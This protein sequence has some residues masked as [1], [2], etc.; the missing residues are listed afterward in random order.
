MTIELLTPSAFAA[1]SA[2][3]VVFDTDL[4]HDL[5]DALALWIAAEL[6]RN[7][8]VVTNDETNGNHRARYARELLDQM[9]RTDVPVVAGR[10]LDGA[11]DRF[12]MH[13]RVPDAR[14]VLTD[15]VEVVTSACENSTQ[16]LI[17]VGC[18]P[19][20]NVAEFFITCPHHIEQIEFTMMG[21]WLDFY[22]NPSRASH[23][24]RMD[25]A[26]F[27][28]VLRAAHQPRLVLSTHTNTDH[29]AITPD[30]HLYTWL[31]AA[32]APPEVELIAANATQ[33]FGHRPSSW[34]N[35]PVTLAAALAV[36]VVEFGT[37]TVRIAK[38]G[39]IHRDPAGRVIEVSIRIDYPDALSWLAEQLPLTPPTP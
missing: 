17:W 3:I 6:V 36:P 20:S 28:L 5:D 19:A 31:T 29:L 4:G 8:I 33:W 16:P 2:P 13:G 12:V 18:G 24:P 37:E 27:G 23:N 38:D 1:E 7:L 30:S 10:A 25:T 15:V 21:G 22:R 11:E 39:R 14:P 34:M 35:D 9:G 32:D 26:S